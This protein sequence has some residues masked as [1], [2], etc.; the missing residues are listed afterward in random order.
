VGEI[1]RSDLTGDGTYGDFIN[2]AS[3]IGH[4]G[5]F[6]R[7]VS[8]H[9]LAATVA[10]FNNTV[11]GTLTPAGQALVTAGLFTQAQ[12]VTLGAV[13]PTIQAP[14]ANN[15]G[16]GWYK[17]VDTVLSW[18]FKLRERLTVLPSVSF[19]NTFN[20]VNYGSLGGLT[21]GDGSINGTSSGVNPATNT[22]RVGRGSGV[23]AVGAPRETEFGLRF[24]F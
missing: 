5:S 24:D 11:A 21:G 14:P 1:F 17:D 15:A 12:L 2:S 16:N 18:P 6:M 8:P 4:P 7:S 3:G 22:Y 9:N 10:N 20:F 13:V 23:F 19:F